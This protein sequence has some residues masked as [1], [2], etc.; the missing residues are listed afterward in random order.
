MIC[1]LALTLVPGI[2]DV[3]A[4]TLVQQLGSA[5]AIF[6]TRSSLLEKIDG[7]GTAR[8]KAIRSFKDF[9]VAEA[10]LAFIEK[11]GIQPLFL[12][13]SR[14]PQ[15]L[16][17]CYDPP[18]LLF[19]KGS[20]DLNASRIVGIVGT[21]NYTEYGKSFTER[22]IEELSPHEV[23][24]VSGLA[25]GIDSFAHRAALRNQLPTVGVVAHGLDKIYP[26][27]NAHMARDMCLQGGLLTEFFSGTKPDRHHFPLRNRIVAGLCDALVV[28][29]TH[30]RGGSMI[31][32]GLANA[33]NRDV[34]A[35]PGRVSDPKSS[36]CNFLIQQNKAV[37]LGSAS[38]LLNIMG[39]KPRQQKGSRQK[40]LFLELTEEEEKL[41]SLLRQKETAS[42][43][44]INLHSGLSS[45]TVA[46][47]LLNLELQGVVSSLP[48]KRY[49]VCEW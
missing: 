5:S 31:T 23:M 16:L 42:I 39:W 30:T 27:L 35:V 38:D 25:I 8:A 14:Y 47:A 28:I 26:Q 3:H 49:Q 36:G 24:I 9:S 1:Q 6:Q 11:W 45:S 21:R 12:T 18:T 41:L 19:Y 7:I 32:A 2:G 40:S 15:R 44:E 29:E 22:F 37:L 34:F 20:A 4:R 46:A 17:H 43:D 10:E 48:G 33:Y 13:D